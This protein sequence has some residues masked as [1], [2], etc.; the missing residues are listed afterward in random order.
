[1]KNNTILKIIMYSLLQLVAFNSIAE[2]N[3]NSIY[4]RWNDLKTDSLFNLGKS[5]LEKEQRDSALICFSICGN[6]ATTEMSKEEKSICINAL[7]NSARL[8]FCFYDYDKACQQLI[9]AIKLCDESKMDKELTGIYMEQGALMM[10]YAQ[11]RPKQQN[12][13]EAEEAYRKSFWNAL[14]HK[15]YSSLI[16]ALFNLG[17]RFYSAQ[18]IEEMKEE[19]DAFNKANIPPTEKSYDYIMNFHH[20]LCHIAD[21]NYPQARYYFNRQLQC[22]PNE[23]R[24][25]IL[26]FQVYTNITKSFVIENNTDSAI[27]YEEIMYDLATKNN[28]IDARTLSASALSELYETQGDSIK[29]SEY[30]I[31]A[32]QLKDSLMSVNNL[33]EVNSLNFIRQLHEE[34]SRLNSYKNKNQWLILVLIIAIT[35]IIIILYLWF[36][37]KKRHKNLTLQNITKKIIKYENSSLEDSTKQELKEKITHVLT[38]TDTIYQQ[39]FCLTQLAELCNS[40]SKYVSQV[41]NELYGQNFTSLINSLR[42]EEACKRMVDKE[43]YGTWTLEGIAQSVGFKSRVTFYNAFKKH[44]EMSPSEY[45]QQHNS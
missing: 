24:N 43:N 8:Y 12:F 11:Q 41:I 3:L 42:V 32:L 9:K 27:Y 6:K 26:K 20:A 40:K 4:S 23:F 34:E 1:M 36:N 25:N 30:S 17:N 21:K 16:T 31:I 38:Q 15:Q 7:T 29:S 19:L 35:A 37:L 10:T 28:M 14:K 13:K 33:D 44:K 5:F 22:I 18:K 45:V 2:E 39:E